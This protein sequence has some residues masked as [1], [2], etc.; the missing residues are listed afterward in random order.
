MAHIL[1]RHRDI[2]D[3][4]QIKIY[5]KN[6]GL[7]PFKNAVTKMKPNEVTDVVKNSGLRGRGGAGFPTGL[8]WE[9]LAKQNGRREKFL[10]CNAD[11]GDPGA[12]MDRSVLESDPHRVIEGMIIA[13]YAVGLVPNLLGESP[14]GVAGG[15]RLLGIPTELINRQL[16][17]ASKVGDAGRAGARFG[18]KVAPHEMVSTPYSA[19]IWLA[20][21]MAAR[22]LMPQ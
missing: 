18:A 22:S 13:A 12:F 6:G 19:Q 2:P 8:K 16:A 3:I 4:N 5:Q 11:E 10:V 14:D 9:L 21:E 17:Q 20:V 15:S 7:A 1:L